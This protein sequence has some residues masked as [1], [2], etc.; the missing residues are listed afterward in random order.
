[1][2]Q[3]KILNKTFITK[4]TTMGVYQE[5]EENPSQGLQFLLNLPVIKSYDNHEINPQKMM[6]SNSDTRIILLDQNNKKRMV[7]VDL[8]RAKVVREF[9]ADKYG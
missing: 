1:M 4:G 2:S 7:E 3:A 6:M 5:D 8:E 9:T